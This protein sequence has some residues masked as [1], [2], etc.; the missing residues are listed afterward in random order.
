MN[1]IQNTQPVGFY[2]PFI[3]PEYCAANPLKQKQERSYEYILYRNYIVLD[4]S[5]SR[6]TQR[7]PIHKHPQ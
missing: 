1:G 6:G 4:Q 5:V 7:F 2:M 3:F